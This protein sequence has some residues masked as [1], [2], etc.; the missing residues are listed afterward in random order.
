M[1]FLKEYKEG[2]E[3]NFNDDLG[4]DI[5]LSRSWGQALK[6]REF[7]GLMQNTYG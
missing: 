5:V 4:I 2:E 3:I 7:N 1:K 6:A